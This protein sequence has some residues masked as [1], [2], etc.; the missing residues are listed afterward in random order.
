[1]VLPD[2]YIDHGAPQDQMDEAGLSAK[3]IAATV[4]TVLGRSREAIHL[5]TNM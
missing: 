3:H 4:L 5:S 2:R 1:M